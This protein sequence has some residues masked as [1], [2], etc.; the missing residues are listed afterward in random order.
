MCLWLRSAEGGL[1]GIGRRFFEEGMFSFRL[2]AYNKA[3]AR[4]G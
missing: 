4:G 3:S 1:R 2:D